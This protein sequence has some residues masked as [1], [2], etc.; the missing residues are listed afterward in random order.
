[1][2]FKYWLPLQNVS[3]SVRLG[4]PRVKM[5]VLPLECVRIKCY[6]KIIIHLVIILLKTPDQNS[7]PDKPLQETNFILIKKF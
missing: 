7:N 4:P 2:K 6:F 1:M 3:L 5:L